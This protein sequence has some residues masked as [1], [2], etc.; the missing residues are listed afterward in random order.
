MVLN[1]EKGENLMID[2]GVEGM[3]EIDSII[4]TNEKLVNEPQTLS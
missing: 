4:E 3:D 2:K 1:K